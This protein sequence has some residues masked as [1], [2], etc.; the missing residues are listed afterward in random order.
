MCENHFVLTG[1]DKPV[2]LHRRD[3][4]RGLWTGS[5]VILGGA[6]TSSCTTNP[7]TGRSQ[8]VFMPESQ[9]I[10]MAAQ[11]WEQTKAEVPISSDRALNARMNRIGERIRAVASERTPSLANADWEF[12][13]FDTDD[14][15][16]FV[17][18]GG[19]VGFYKGLIEFSDN[20][21]Q[22]AAVLGHEVGH[23]EGRHANERMSQ[24]TLGQVGLVAAGVAASAS[25]LSSTEQQLIMAAAGA[26]LTLGIILPFSRK[27]EL[28]ADLLGVDSMY[29]AGYDVRESVRLWQKMGEGRSGAPPEW[30]ST[31]PSPQTRVREL[32]NYINNKGYA[33]M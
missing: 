30:M 29:A 8:L 25:E 9:L 19:K 13:V 21:D 26:G 16:A 1:S 4:V 27:H 18:P 5:M 33:R 2:E 6:S 20:D 12:V 17:M 14:K 23:V 22:V 32:T 3:V 15:N 11:A 31:H 10:G 7:A 24:Q 28:E